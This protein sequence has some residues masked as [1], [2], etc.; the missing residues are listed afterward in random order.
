MKTVIAALCVIFAGG[1]FCLAEIAPA[2]P[3]SASLSQKLDSIIIPQVQFHDAN[4]NDVIQYLTAQGKL[5][6]PDRK[7]VNIVLMDK[8]NKSR[9]YMSVRNISLRK[10]LI[11]LATMADLSLEIE[12][13]RTSVMLKPKEKK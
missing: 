3:S 11:S 13:G 10:A 5:R 4:I 6:D 8:E 1:L 2:R 9:V 12:E 7:G